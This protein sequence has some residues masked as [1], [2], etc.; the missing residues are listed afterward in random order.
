MEQVD[1]LLLAGQAHEKVG[2]LSQAASSFHNAASWYQYP[3]PYK[4]TNSFF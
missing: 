4:I 2:N 3:L 1:V